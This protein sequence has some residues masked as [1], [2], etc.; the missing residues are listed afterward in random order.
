VSVSLR[1]PTVL[2]SLTHEADTTPV[3]LRTKRF[4]VNLLAADQRALSERF[5]QAIPA[6][7]KFASL[8]LHRRGSGPARLEG[9]LAWLECDVEQTI[10]Y[11]DHHLILGRVVDLE[12]GADGMPLLF[13][14]S[15]YGETAG[16]DSVRLPP[17]RR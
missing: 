10:V 4:V 15:R 5:A 8:P 13:Y 14:R 3:L 16:T 1:P 6:T 12:P 2:I 17:G 7:D 9:A 11:S